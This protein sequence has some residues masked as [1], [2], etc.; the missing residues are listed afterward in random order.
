MHKTSLAAELILEKLFQRYRDL[1]NK[2]YNDESTPKIKTLI[3][4]NLSNQKI[5]NEILNHY[6]EIEDYE[7]FF[8]I[9]N[10]QK[11]D[12]DVL[13]NLSNQLIKRRLPKIKI[14]DHPFTK[15]QIDTQL[16]SLKKNSN[17]EN[18][19]FYVFK[20]ISQFQKIIQ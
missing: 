18:Q 1:I 10:W 11:N 3:S 13:R 19:N 8:L 7:V 12:D 15:N 6:L 2:G 9:K 17:V 4:L 5:P 14:Q 20:K 16:Q